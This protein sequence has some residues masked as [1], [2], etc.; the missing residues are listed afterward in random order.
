MITSNPCLESTGIMFQSHVGTDLH[1]AS[2]TFTV[3]DSSGKLTNA[4][5]IDCKCV[6]KIKD[7]ITSLPKPIHC[8]I[9]S[10]GM[11]EWL[12]EL[13]EPL[14]DKLTLADAVEL[15]Y[16][17][18]RRQ[19]KTDRIDS[20]FI[21]LLTYKGELPVSFVPDK[22]TR[23]FRRVCRHWHAT[24]EMLSG[25]KVRMRWILLQHNL[26]GPAHLTGDS[27]RRW[28]K[29]HG[30]LLDSIAFFSFSQFLETVEHIELQQLTIRRQMRQFSQLPQFKDDIELCCTVPGIAEILAAIIVAEVAGFHRFDSAQA[31]ACYTG[32]TE[33]THE[34][35]GK[36][37]Q[38][39]VSCAGP[40]SLRWALCEA[41]TTLVRSDPSYRGIY[42]H[43]VKNTGNKSK[44][45]VAM[46]RKLITWLWKMAQT[47]QPFI[48]G[49]ST[50][51][52]R[53]A[54]IARQKAKSIKNLASAC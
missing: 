49:G 11:Y 51:H 35:G 25:I 39:H 3:I 32:L 1:K 47:R 13:L 19:A 2:L 7:F 31:I 48:R 34:S 10:V 16:R 54:N 50:N 45:K 42:N 6:N 14:V 15:N 24:S 33:R 23:Q 52:N 43:L 20:K 17:A 41:A 30:H 37:S 36:R 9:E 8:A 21:S 22:T 12:W 28:L 5:D 40:A 38:G 4:A 26:K 44:A 29:A 46:A 18:G 27:T 53:N